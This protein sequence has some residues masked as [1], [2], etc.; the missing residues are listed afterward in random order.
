MF[1][2]CILNDSH[3]GVCEDG[4]EDC[5]DEDYVMVRSEKRGHSMI[6]VHLQ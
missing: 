4:D 5:N 2:I 1:F 6:R 3:K